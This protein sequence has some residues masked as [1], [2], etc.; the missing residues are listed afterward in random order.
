MT[1]ENTNPIQHFTA[2][3]E[4]TIF[5]ISFAVEGKDNI[6]VTVNGSVVSVND[7]SYDTLTKA[8][9]FNAA[10]EDGAEVV[11]ERVTSLDRSINYQTYN[12]SFRPETLNYDLDRIWHVLQEDKITDAEILGRIKNEIEW[13]RTHNTEWDLL[14]QTREQGLFN[15]LKS[16]MDTIG[17]MSVPNLF[18]G[19]TD[20]VVITEEGVSQRVTNR[21][22]K[23]QQA[24]LGQALNDLN[25]IVGGNYEAVRDY[26]DLEKDR[27]TSQELLLNEAIINETAR[28]IGAEN[29]IR[30]LAESISGGYITAKATL[31]ELQLVTGTVG[32][33]A[34]VMD[35]GLYSGDYYYNG[36]SWIKGYSPLADT[37][38]YVESNIKSVPSKNLFNKANAVAGEYFSPSSNSIISHT[39][40][41]RSGFLPVIAGQAYTLS[42]N[43]VGGPIAWYATADKTSTPIS[44]TTSSAN[45]VAPTGANFA[46]FNITNT[47]GT[48]TTYDQTTQFEKGS[49]S[50]IYEEYGTK[51][52]QILISNLE[53]DLESKLNKSEIVEVVSFNL[54]DPTKINFTKRYSTGTQGFVSDALL[55][56]AT[57]YI[58]VKEGEWYTLSGSAKYGAVSGTGQG[59]Y[60]ASNT[61]QIAL[62]NISFVQPVTGNGHAFKVPTGLGIKYVVL[63][64]VKTADN[65]LNG[66]A[67]L[68]LGEM[69]TAYQPYE[70]KLKIKTEVLPE[71]LGSGSPSQPTT[72]FNDATWFKYTQADGA[73][74]DSH[75]LP[76]F[77]KHHLLKDKDLTVVMTGTSLSARTTEHSTGHP[78]A[79][80]RPP[81]M[82]SHALCS[83]LWDAM[84]WEGQQYRRY[85]SG[86]F[87][88]T[89]SFLTASNLTEWDDGPYRDGLTRYT[90][91][92]SAS[93]SFKIPSEA[94]QF[95]FIYRTDSLG[96]AAK[97]TVAEG[98]GKVQ[99]YDETTNSWVEAHNYE[100]SQVETAPVTRSVNIPS[101]VT[102]TITATTLASKGNT[103]YQKRLKMRCRDNIS[104]NSL[105]TEKNITIAKNSITGRF[106]Y[107]GVEWSPRQYMIT[108]INSA[109]G[110]H[111][112]SATSTSGLPRY[113]DNEVWSFKPDLIFSELAIHN[114]GAAS[115]GS[116][117]VGQ[118]AGLAYNYITNTDYE[119]SMYSRSA[120]FGLSPE[121]VFYMGTITWNF[122]GINEDGS[123]K[124]GLQTS[125]VKG[126]VKAMSAL[127]KY[128]EAVQFLQENA[129]TISV[130]NTA[131]RWV[132]A[133]VSIFGDMKAATVGSG[134][135]G[136][137]FTNEG[138]HWND[139]GSLIMA[140]ALIPILK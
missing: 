117:P 38:N 56:A 108:F 53:Q 64:L 83:H 6:K 121:Y 55:I 73:S 79:I 62:S 123:L 103:T 115:A 10:P 65:I 21:D 72:S 111:N 8:V 78:K 87:T 33:V 36:T 119:L 24:N 76:K 27:A 113:Q 81:M 109:R 5:A 131:K 88:E 89:G 80:F 57:D 52:P 30:S 112:T 2:N 110:S 75:K 42:G 40:Y 7:Y 93:I 92:E 77:R 74:I 34:K 95:N 138:S 70:A 4:T 133:G 58:P 43:K 32:Q 101:P 46:V 13:R 22:L 41:R 54:I 19:I 1:V 94:W 137:T 9:V 97:I 120:Y 135:A 28:A 12:N 11:V 140:K 47:G 107:W 50:T 134:K 105:G 90:A 132:E 49:K 3:G 31:N 16:Y 84:M 100:F 60:F 18:D 86:F 122:G 125:S 128:D 126:G 91:S 61:D 26:I 71:G 85:D 48:D 96:S 106:M 44:H 127:D 130:V 39:T 23:Q 17:A 37:I 82:H 69:P 51:I 15:A 14:A 63:S 116:Y 20:N 114:D 139:T 35:D 99:V 45:V 124:Y 104:L 67:Q 68:E 129:P 66:E 98:I 118:W 59:G 25:S 29:S 136:A 102:A